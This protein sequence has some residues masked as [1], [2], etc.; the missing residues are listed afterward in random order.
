VAARTPLQC[1]MDAYEVPSSRF[2]SSFCFNNGQIL[3]TLTPS[4]PRGR[5]IS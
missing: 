3:H 2:L 1:G 4:F 5:L